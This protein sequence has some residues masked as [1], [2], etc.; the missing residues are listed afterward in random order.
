MKSNRKSH[1]G[2]NDVIEIPIEG[3]FIPMWG[4]ISQYQNLLKAPKHNRK[5]WELNERFS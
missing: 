1:S 3:H 4:S 5:P 2:L